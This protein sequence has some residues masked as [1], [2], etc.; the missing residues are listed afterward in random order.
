MNKLDPLKVSSYNY[1]L[2]D[3]LIATSPTYP[4][5]RQ[6]LLVYDR[7]KD[8]ITHTTFGN[9]FDFIPKE[10]AIILNDTKVIKARIYGKKESGGKIELLL[11][12]PLCDNRYLVYIRGRVKV[13]TKLYFDNNLNAIVKKL[14][15]DGSREVEFFYHKEMIDF[16]KLT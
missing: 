13:G 8:K 5:E 2:P 15:M 3:E 7:K 9:I 6:K 12:S 4:K 1:H 10:T 11:N 16:T 14:N